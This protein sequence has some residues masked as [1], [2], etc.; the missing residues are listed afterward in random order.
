MLRIGFL[1]NV[2]GIATIAAAVA[3]LGPLLIAPRGV[4][5]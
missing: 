5:G 4:T 3:I 1:L 2:L